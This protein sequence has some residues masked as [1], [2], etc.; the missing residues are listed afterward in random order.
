MSYLLWINNIIVKE[1]NEEYDFLNEMYPEIKDKYNMMWAIRNKAEK[2]MSP[3]VR[4][5]IK[6]IQEEINT[7]LKI[8]GAKEH[9][10]F[11][12]KEDKLVEPISGIEFDINKNSLHLKEATEEEAKRYVENLSN[13]NIKFLS[14]KMPQFKKNIQIL[15][16]KVL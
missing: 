6:K 16:K 1:N 3:S 11:V 12:T 13:E 9:I 14:S 2:P 8:L 7:S 4:N 10:L 5:K 15:D